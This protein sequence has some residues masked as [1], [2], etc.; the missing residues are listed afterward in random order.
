MKSQTCE[1]KIGDIWE[2][3]TGTQWRVIG[4]MLPSYPR[5]ET[6]TWPNGG[7]GQCGKVKVQRLNP[8]KWD[9]GIYIWAAESFEAMAL[10]SRS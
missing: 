3:S 6:R 1:I 10:V 5:S 9:D 2:S 7:A 4:L 8:P